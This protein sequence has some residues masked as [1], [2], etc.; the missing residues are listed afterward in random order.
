MTGLTFASDNSLVWLIV[1]M[2]LITVGSRLLGFFVVGRSGETPL[3]RALHYLPYGLFAAIIVTST[4]G[5]KGDVAEL[6]PVI[7]AALVTG[8][9]AWRRMPLL[10]SLGLGMAMALIFERLV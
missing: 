7:T 5:L 8:W 4:P 10:L 2:A 6:L 3:G 9:T 1:L